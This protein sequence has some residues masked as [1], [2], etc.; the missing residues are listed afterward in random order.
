MTP[1]KS[2]TESSLVDKRFEISILD[3]LRDLTEIVEFLTKDLAPDEIAYDLKKV[4]NL[5]LRP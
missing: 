4:R 3:L 5:Y 2:D 1:I